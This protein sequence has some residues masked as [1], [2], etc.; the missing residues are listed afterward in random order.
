MGIKRVKSGWRVDWRDEYGRRQRRT[1]DSKTAADNFLTQDRAKIQAAKA[2]V[3]PMRIKFIEFA[4]SWLEN[5]K[6]DCEE[7]NKPR[8]YEW[9]LVSQR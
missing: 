7:R 9:S 4:T 6:K 8:T 3:L 5:V 1:F 2:K